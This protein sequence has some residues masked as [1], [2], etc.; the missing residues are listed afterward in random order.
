MNYINCSILASSF[1]FLAGQAVNAKGLTS[2]DKKQ[3]SWWLKRSDITLYKEFPFPGEK[4]IV[5][6]QVEVMKGAILKHKHKGQ[7][8]RGFHAKSQA[9]FNGKLEILPNLKPEYSFGVFSEAKTFDI[10]GRFSNGSGKTSSDK[11]PDPRGLAIKVLNASL[12]VEEQDFLA[13]N[14]PVFPTRNIKGFLD[15]HKAQLAG[16]FKL[17]A[18]M[19]THPRVAGIL[20][21]H[22]DNNIGSLL[23]I[24]YWSGGAFK[25][26]ERAGK[27]LF[28]PC[29]KLN[30]VKKPKN[31]DWHYLRDDLK[32]R[33]QAEESCFKLQVQLQ[34]DPIN[35]PIEDPSIEWDG[36][37]FVTVAHIK[38]PKQNL[39]IGGKC[40]TTAFSP[41]NTMDEHKP[42][43]NINRIRKAVYDASKKFREKK[44]GSFH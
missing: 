39:I 25:M 9:C 11:S 44:N 43:G 5:Q 33:N 16:G 22:I 34:A 21:K 24:N 30:G 38:I 1:V 27:Y 15:F 19:A 31:P 29:K 10:W 40:E 42:L 41:W 26:G 17:A 28:T 37:P 13:V 14:S 12:E 36:A 6:K 2:D 18:Y 20:F 32:K 23:A 35:H 8:R 3:N 7:H 4:E